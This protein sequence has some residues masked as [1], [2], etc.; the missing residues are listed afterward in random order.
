[1]AQPSWRGLKLKGEKAGSG[2]SFT[3]LDKI[4][5]GFF[6]PSA[7]FTP[8]VGHAPPPGRGGATFVGLAMIVLVT[9]KKRLSFANRSEVCPR[10]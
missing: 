10:G 9:N 1:M 4:N 8:T 6:V 2:A 7:G 3:L 5:K